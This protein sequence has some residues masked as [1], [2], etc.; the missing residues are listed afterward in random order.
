MW[1]LCGVYVAVKL[2]EIMKILFTQSTLTKFFSWLDS[3]ATNTEYSSPN[4]ILRKNIN[5]PCLYFEICLISNK[6]GWLNFHLPNYMFIFFFILP[7]QHYIESEQLL[8]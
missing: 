6:I 2:R 7:C 4:S 3:L 1:M 5:T 8:V